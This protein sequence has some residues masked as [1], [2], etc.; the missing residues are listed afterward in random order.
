MFQHILLFSKTGKT[1]QRLQD[2]LNLQFKNGVK[3]FQSYLNEARLVERF[4]K[5][6][7]YSLLTD[8]IA[9]MQQLQKKSYE[10]ALFLDI[11]GLP[12]S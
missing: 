1:V 8:G 5:A 11:D 12:K 7:Y 2:L 9:Q 10:Y 4:S 3:E 6:N